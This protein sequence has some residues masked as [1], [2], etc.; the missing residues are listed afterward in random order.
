MSKGGRKVVGGGEI[1]LELGERAFKVPGVTQAPEGG[2]R[3]Q[4]LHTTV[5]LQF[6]VLTCQTGSNHPM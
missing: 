1:G 4:W 6:I 2:K 5:N 3:H